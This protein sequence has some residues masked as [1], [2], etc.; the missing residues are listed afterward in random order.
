MEV[1]KLINAMHSLDPFIFKS[2]AEQ[3]EV[4]ERFTTPI[5]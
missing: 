4:A 5:S 3:M 1:L 2:K